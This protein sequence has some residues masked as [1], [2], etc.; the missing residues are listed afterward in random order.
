MVEIIIVCLVGILIALLGQGQIH[1]A[2][3]ENSSSI[4]VEFV[5]AQ[6]RVVLGIWVLVEPMRFS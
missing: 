1:R 4:P 2:V 5:P 6:L 3:N